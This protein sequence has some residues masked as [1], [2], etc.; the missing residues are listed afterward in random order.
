[1]NIKSQFC[2]F[3]MKCKYE[4][5]YVELYLAFHQ[6]LD[7]KMTYFGRQSIHGEDPHNSNLLFVVKNI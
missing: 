6:E 5:V 2:L 7:C 1:M 3:T 4:N